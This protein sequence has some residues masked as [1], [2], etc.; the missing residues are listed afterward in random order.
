VI[1]GSIAW[2]IGRSISRPL[3]MLGARMQALADGKPDG[4]IPGLGRGDEVGAMAATVQIFK[5]NALRI[6]G[7]EEAEAATQARAAAERRTA[8]EN[9]ASDFERS[10]TGIVRS[11]S[12]A[13]A[14]MQTT[15]QSMTATASDPARA[16]RPSARPPRVHRTTSA[17]LRPRP[18]SFRAR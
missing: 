8:M 7:L 11:V 13:A 3:G 5:D 1:S 18:K 2:V 15:A 17:R 9:I 4:E 12:T 10:V 6:R 14:G 16:P